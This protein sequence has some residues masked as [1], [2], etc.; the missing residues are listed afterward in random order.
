MRVKDQ[1]V[2]VT[3][4]AGGIGLGCAKRFAAEGARV[5]VSDVDRDQGEAAAEALQAEGAEAVFVACDVGDRAAVEALVDSAVAAFGR[6][7]CMV[8][9]AGIVKAGDF[10]DFTEEDFD[11]VIRVNLKGV[12][13]CGQ[14]AARRM[15]AQN[16]RPDGSRGT[17]INMSS[18]NAVVA[19]P[20]ITP[21][22]VAK[23]G[24]NQLTK[25]MALA[26]ADKGVRVNAVGPGSINTPMVSAVND[27]PEAWK[28]LMSRTPMG[29]LG[30]PEEMGNVAVFLASSDSSYITGQTLYADGGRLGLN[31]TV[32][33]AD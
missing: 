3:G 27:D 29:R 17:I 11:A 5:V 15:V 6:L 32:P 31:Y 24:V 19:I 33:V 20:S 14:A 4:A 18:I 25:V 28:R 8:A 21:Y 23:G 22:C 13:L 7:D 30:E 26:L 10:L 16:A 2:V 9:N 1:V 12:F